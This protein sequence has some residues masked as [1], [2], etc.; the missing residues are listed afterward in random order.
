MQTFSNSLRVPDVENPACGKM[1][2]WVRRQIVQVMTCYVIRQAFKEAP[3]WG[4]N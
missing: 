1:T 3:D 2:S 4:P